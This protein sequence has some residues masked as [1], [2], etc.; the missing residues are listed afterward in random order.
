MRIKTKRATSQPARRTERGAALITTLLIATLLFAAGGAL[1][2]STAATGTTVIDATVEKQAYYAAE[3]GLQMTMNALRG[4]LAHSTAVATGTKMN[5]RTAIMPDLS[6]GTGLSTNTPC[7]TDTPTA[8]SPCRLAGWLTYNSNGLISVGPDTSFR[9]TVYDPD[10]SNQ[11]TYSTSGQFNGLAGIPGTI[12]SATQIRLGVAPDYVTIT[13]L[14]KASTTINNAYPS[15]TTDLGSFQV[16]KS[17][18]AALLPLNVGSFVSF[19]LT[20]NQTA[21]WSGTAVYKLTLGTPAANLCP[22]EL[23]HVSVPTPSLKAGG[24]SLTVTGLTAGKLA[25]GCPA[26]GATTT[27]QVQA[28]VVAPEPRRVVVRSIGFGTNFARKQLEMMVQRADLDFAAPATLT[29]RGADDCSALD[30]DTGNSGAKNY[31]GLDHAPGGQEPPRPAFA[32]MDCSLASTNAGIKKPGTI[33]DPKIGVMDNANP[34]AP[35]LPV[36]LPSYLQTADNARQYLNDL[37]TT[38]RAQGRYFKQA[39]SMSSNAGTATNPVL[40]FVDGDCTLDGGAGFLVVTGN[41]TMSGNPSF[42]GV[43]IVMGGGTVTRNGGGNGSYNGA[44]V[45]A[46]FARTWPSSENGTAHP[47]LSP[48]FNTNGGGNSDFQYNSQSV[49]N[50]LTSLGSRIAGVLEY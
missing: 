31:S 16:T 12:I 11:V 28:T 45:V 24:T 10:R 35:Y 33:D 42:D 48:T 2:L 19:R 40:T 32:V 4:N 36:D 46:K 29:I 6:N 41:L 47:F 13:Y 26:V 15:A 3:A 37:E 23:F 21:P 22:G 25:L 43:V 30:F 18:L 34:P 8:P 38:A 20:V 44:M 5:F 7:I 39:G 27:Q 14:P 50:A 9:S 49:N 17:T 1:I